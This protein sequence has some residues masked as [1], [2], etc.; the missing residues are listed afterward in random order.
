MVSVFPWWRTGTLSSLG[1]QHRHSLFHV[2]PHLLFPLFVLPWGARL[3]VLPQGREGDLVGQH[4]RGL[5]AG[6]SDKCH[7]S[8]SGGFQKVQLGLFLK[9]CSILN[10]SVTPRQVL[11]RGGEDLAPLLG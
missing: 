8:C 11:I 2:S 9:A 7:C 10:V 5:T 4:F 6:F 1:S 3:V